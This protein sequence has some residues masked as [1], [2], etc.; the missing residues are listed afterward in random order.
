MLIHEVDISID[1]P[2]RM[3]YLNISSHF[4]STGLYIW[5]NYS[6]LTTNRILSIKSVK[7]IFRLL[8]NWSVDTC[9]LTCDNALRK[10]NSKSVKF[11]TKSTHFE[12]FFQGALNLGPTWCTLKKFSK[13]VLSVHLHFLCRLYNALWKK[14]YTKCNFWHLV[15]ICW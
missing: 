10:K 15:F 12:K 1:G 4:L 8:Q 14:I 11:G 7:M 9:W 3:V 6:L 2:H 5:L 13:C